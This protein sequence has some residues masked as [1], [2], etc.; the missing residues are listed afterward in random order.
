MGITRALFNT[1]LKDPQFLALLEDCEIDTA[2]KFD[3]FDALDV[4]MG[5]TLEIHELVNGLMRLRG[6]VSETDIVA[7][8]LKI[9]HVTDLTMKIFDKVRD[10][11]SIYLLQASILG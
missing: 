11:Q 10:L 9:R 7:M 4:D 1:W 8:R 5:G 2:T 3:L 6:P